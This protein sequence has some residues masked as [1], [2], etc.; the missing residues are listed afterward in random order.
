MV[1]VLLAHSEFGQNGEDAS[2]FIM[3]QYYITYN[4]FYIIPENIAWFI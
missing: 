4:I 2:H 3:K 1:V